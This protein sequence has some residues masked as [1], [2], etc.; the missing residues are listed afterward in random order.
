[1]SDDR[2]KHCFEA[3]QEIFEGIQFFF[4]IFHRCSLY[5]LCITIIDTQFFCLKK[6]EYETGHRQ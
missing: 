3:I 4:F 2:A 1:M 6:T 5:G